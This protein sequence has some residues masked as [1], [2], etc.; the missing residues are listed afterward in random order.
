MSD[1]SSTRYTLRDLP[2][3]AKLVVSLFLVSVGLGYFSALWQ[4]HL[5]HA[6][7]GSLVPT[8]EDVV[9]RFSGKYWGPEQAPVQNAAA[10]ENPLDALP[11]EVKIETLIKT[12]CACCHAQ[13]GDRESN[14]PY[15]ESWSELATALGTKPMESMVFKMITTEPGV[16]FGKGTSM[17]AAFTTKS[18]VEGEKWEKYVK[19]LP[20]E[21]V[22]SLKKER[23]AE[24][25][26]MV[27]WLQ[28]GSTETLKKSYEADLFVRPEKVAPPPQET[29]ETKAKRRQMEVESLTQSTHA[30][31]LSFS[32]LWAL[33]GLTFAFTGYSRWL[34]LGLAPAVLLAQIADV[35][36]WW[37][38]RLPDV[39]PYFA[40]AIMGTGAVV[41]LGLALQIVLSLFSMYGR[42]GRIVLVVLMIAGCMGAGC[43]YCKYI[44]PEVQAEKGQG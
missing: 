6:G 10:E 39:G 16:K 8:A 2:L 24:R 9:A 36:C 19:G 27:L 35:S 44:V 43:V 30:H 32:M 1:V 13:D 31:L 17:R 28:S 21:K 23:E 37:L 15:L 26:M 22:A 38:A 41:G 25:Q 7:K 3:P 4:L 12:R 40:L 33:T 14:K 29:R 20:E 5:R 42:K 34:R 18:E 11:K